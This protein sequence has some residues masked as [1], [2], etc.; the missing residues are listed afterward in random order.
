MAIETGPDESLLLAIYAGPLEAEPWRGFLQRY[1]EQLKALDLGMSI[2]MPQ[3]GSTPVWL[4]DCTSDPRHI[5]QYRQT[6]FRQDPWHT[7]PMK[8]GDVTTM[9]KVITPDVLRSTPFFREFMHEHGALH[10]MR[11]VICSDEAGSASLLC[12][13][14]KEQGNFTE[15][16]L[17]QCKAMLPHLQQA[18][19]SYQALVL[20]QL[21]PCNRDRAA[22]CQRCCWMLRA[23]GCHWRRASR[24]WRACL[25]SRCM[26]AARLC[27]RRKPTA[28]CRR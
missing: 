1:R 7:H 4:H 9:D 27:R 17:A 26:R 11:A 14:S 28:S 3:L 10:G 25:S 23:I 12:G 13:R 15:Q 8:A 20:A 22:A 16:D 18:L 24:T 5:A 19:R 6:Y 21:R 2:R